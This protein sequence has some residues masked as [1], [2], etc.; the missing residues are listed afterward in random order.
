MKFTEEKLEK[1]FTELLAAE[2]FWHQHGNSIDRKPDDVLIEEDLRN[3]LL[4]RYAAQGITTNEANSI[5]LKLKSLPA[6]DLYESNKTFLKML[7]DGIII[8]REDRRQ[9][10]IYIQLIN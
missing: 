8:K 4:T 3:F 5:I 6:S 7:S 1:A 2:G 9:K 10:D